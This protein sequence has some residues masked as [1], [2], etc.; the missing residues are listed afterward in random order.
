MSLNLLNIPEHKN[1]K[2]CGKCCGVIPATKKEVEAI[3]K[4][5]TERGIKPLSPKGSETCPFRDN[6]QKKCLIYP[7]RP[8]ICRL[9]GVAEGTMKCENGN[10]ANIDG[11]RFLS[12]IKANDVEILNYIDW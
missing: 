2:N 1:C 7:V 8:L 11:K 10:S 5:I 4:Y 12:N 6:V 3:R 9:Y